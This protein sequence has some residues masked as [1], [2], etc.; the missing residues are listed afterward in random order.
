LFKK[1]DIIDNDLE[2][3]FEVDENLE[4]PEEDE[5]YIFYL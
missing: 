2:E 5:E 1:N 4:I 3:S